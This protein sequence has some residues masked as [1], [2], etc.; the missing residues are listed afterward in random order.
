MASAPS[1]FPFLPRFGVFSSAAIALVG[2][3]TESLSSSLPLGLGGWE[4][5]RDL[6]PRIIWQKPISTSH[7]DHPGSRGKLTQL[8]TPPINPKLYPAAKSSPRPLMLPEMLSGLPLS[9]PIPCP[10]ISRCFKCSNAL[11]IPV[12]LVGLF[13]P[14]MPNLPPFPPGTGAGL[15]GLLF[16]QNCLNSFPTSLPV[17]VQLFRML[18]L[19]SVTWRR[20]SS[21]F[22]FSQLTLSSLREAPRLNWRAMYFS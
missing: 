18:S 20:R 14:S 12:V 22:F 5:R 7:R 2:L 1:I 6:L 19:S 17:L 8:L 11:P 15:A 9:P 16:C 3:F 21:S 13:C 4:P 10:G